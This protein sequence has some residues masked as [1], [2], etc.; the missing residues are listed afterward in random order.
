[1]WTVSGAMLVVSFNWWWSVAKIGTVCVG[2]G[3]MVQVYGGLR[4]FHGSDVSSGCVEFGWSG[5]SYGVGRSWL[6]RSIGVGG[7][8]GSRLLR[9]RRRACGSLA[10]FAVFGLWLGQDEL[11]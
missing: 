9:Y 5:D 3:H 4:A 8:R 1:M 10:F 6:A 2:K 11:S 7:S